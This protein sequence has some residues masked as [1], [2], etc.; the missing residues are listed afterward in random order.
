[1]TTVKLSEI[2]YFNRA[3]NKPRFLFRRLKQ[4][5]ALFVTEYVLTHFIA[6][7]I[8]QGG[9]A[10]KKDAVDS[11]FLDPVD[12]EEV[13]LGFMKGHF[14]HMTTTIDQL[15][16][17]YSRHEELQ[18]LLSMF[19]DHHLS[20]LYNQLEG[21]ME[22][23]LAMKTS[24]QKEAEIRNYK[25]EWQGFLDDFCW[26]SS[27]DSNRYQFN[28]WQTT[29]HRYCLLLE[30]HRDRDGIFYYT[31][32]WD[33]K[34][35]KLKFICPSIHDRERP[36]EYDPLFF[37]KETAIKERQA[38]PLIKRA[39]FLEDEEIKHSDTEQKKAITFPADRHLVIL[40]GAGSGKTRALV[41]RVAYLHLV[42]G[43][44]LKDIHQL[45]FNLLQM[46]QKRC[47]IEAML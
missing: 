4:F 3:L 41:S 44:S 37:K 29:C 30:D 25:E 2:P 36:Y 5:K 39:Q 12:Q 35:K 46:Q 31:F 19:P 43:I 47:A 17:E 42:K 1:M 20:S 40:A 18:K 10:S 45:T 26:A 21:E 33:E 6:N 7:E 9:R 34:N 16:N 24:A 32:L 38:L 28:S 27:A 22:W 8:E 14:V 23:K 11:R 15:V 13:L